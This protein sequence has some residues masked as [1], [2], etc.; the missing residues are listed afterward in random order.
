MAATNDLE[1]LSQYT[2]TDI[3][4]HILLGCLLAHHRL[5]LSSRIVAAIMDIMAYLSFGAPIY[6]GW[7]YDEL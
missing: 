6:A 3:A 7:A 1:K 2:N 5:D 4:R